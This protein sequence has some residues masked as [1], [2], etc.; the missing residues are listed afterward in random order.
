MI[1]QLDVFCRKQGKWTAV[2]YVQACMVLYQDPNLRASYRMCLAANQSSNPPPGILD[3]CLNRLPLD[4]PRSLRKQAI[5][6]SLTGP[7]N[8]PK[9][10]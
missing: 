6:E 4:K 5:P 9:L 8:R 3:D 1:Y 2:P 10:L 7:S